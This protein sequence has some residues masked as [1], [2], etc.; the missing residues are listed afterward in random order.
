MSDLLEKLKA[1]LP[2]APGDVFGYDDAMIA[3]QDSEIFRLHALCAEAASVLEMVGLRAITLGQ[4][5]A[6]LCALTVDLVSN[7]PMKIPATEHMS[8][9]LARMTDILEQEKVVRQSA[10]K[11]VEDA[12]RITAAQTVSAAGIAQDAEEIKPTTG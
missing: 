1:P 10:A 4:M 8:K 9:A 5:S 2:P 6:N 3:W 12:A 11:Q 7:L